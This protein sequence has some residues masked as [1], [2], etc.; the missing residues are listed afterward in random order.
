LW[1]NRNNENEGKEDF[2]MQTQTQIQSENSALKVLVKEKNNQLK[3]RD[4]Q[5]K[6]L[7]ALNNWYMQ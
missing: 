4:E 6:K 5:I 3:Q 7:E 2:F 1:Y